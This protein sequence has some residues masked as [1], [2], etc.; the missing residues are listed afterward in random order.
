VI[1]R[2]RMARLSLSIL[3]AVAAISAAAVGPP[4]LR[5]LLK[6]KNIRRGVVR[7]LDGFEVAYGAGSVAIVSATLFF[8]A[9]LYVARRT[10]KERVRA[11]HMFLLCA[12]TLAGIVLIE[13]AAAG[14]L[15]LEHFRAPSARR[16]ARPMPRIALPTQFDESGGPSETTLV[17]L[18]D[19]SA[20]GLPY[21]RWLSIDRI[22]CWQLRQ[23]FPGRRFRSE[24]F[25][26]PGDTLQI[27]HQKLA[28][29]RRRPDVL[30]VYCGHNEFSARDSAWRTPPHY[31]DTKLDRPRRI[32]GWTVPAASPLRALMQQTS[33]HLKVPL[34]PPAQGERPAVDVPSY[35]PEEYTKRLADF[36]TRLEAIVAYGERVGAL[37]VLIIPP[38]N[39]SGFDPNRS[40][41][42]PETT[43]VE[44][45]AFTRE[46]TEIR[47][48][49]SQKPAAAI[50]RYRSLLERQPTSADGHFRLARLLERSGSIPEA[51]QHD[52]LA[53]DRDGYPIRCPTEFQDV[54]REVAA[55]HSCLLIDGPAVC[56]QASP[57]GLLD[58]HL[59][60]DAM[61]PSLAG[62]V[63][64][65]QA[66]LDAFSHHHA[67]GWSK[68]LRRPIIDPAECAR[69]FGLDS[70]AW[71]SVC[72]QGR[73]FYYTVSG[74][75]R[76]SSLRREKHQAFAEASRRIAAGEPAESVGLANVGIPKFSINRLPPDGD[77]RQ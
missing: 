1:S 60:H 22:L 3:I 63:V 46:M 34:Q 37:P 14:W 51:Y 2:A 6:D 54:Y 50:A 24:V 56:R 66:I 35:F 15:A 42:A 36:R 58:N 20:F 25:A 55:R 5:T 8:G 59:F 19:S 11:A 53:R 49:E 48:L 39:D 17:V 29:L 74:M 28:N 43:Q 62:Y 21:D 26:N 45:E 18:G 13:L 10:R 38:A 33:D 4:W 31:L 30:I 9:I 52:V 32:L 75:R 77:I 68:N 23:V 57:T 73:M 64:L 76:D 40:Y 72:E 7:I 65:S 27:Q 70:K 41:L 67:L 12:G 69:H 71:Q 61:H 47:Q 16:R 44:R